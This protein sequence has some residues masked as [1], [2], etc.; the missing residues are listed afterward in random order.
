MAVLV[1]KSFLQNFSP[2]FHFFQN[3]FAAQFSTTF[4]FLKKQNGG[5]NFLDILL[6]LL[7]CEEPLQ[8]S[9]LAY[10]RMPADRDVLHDPLFRADDSPQ[11]KSP[12]TTPLPRSDYS[13][14]LI[15]LHQRKINSYTEKNNWS[16]ALERDQCL[17]IVVAV[18]IVEL[19]NSSNKCLKFMR[20]AHSNLQRQNTV[21]SHKKY[22]TLQ[23]LL[24]M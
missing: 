3:S 1:K 19:I 15:S 4:V 18:Q 16:H 2:N 9:Q 6:V 24:L 12:S 5:A 11:R 22:V 13:H 21:Y 23:H 8:Q 17:A 14:P 10:A 20:A 7:R